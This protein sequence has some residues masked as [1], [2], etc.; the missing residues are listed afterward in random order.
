M[1]I[2]VLLDLTMMKNFLVKKYHI[3]NVIGALM[4]FAYYTRSDIVFVINLLSKI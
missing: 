4:Y 2:N 3:F 1:L